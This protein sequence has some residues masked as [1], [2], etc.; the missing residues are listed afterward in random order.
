MLRAALGELSAICCLPVWTWNGAPPELFS[1]IEPFSIRYIE[2]MIFPILLNLFK[3][4]LLKFILPSIFELFWVN[5][6]P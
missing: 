5:I 2:F 1:L 6:A 3:G 4:L